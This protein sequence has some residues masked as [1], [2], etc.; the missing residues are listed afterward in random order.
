VTKL[1]K[2]PSENSDWNSIGTFKYVL[3]A[4]GIKEYKI[5]SDNSEKYQV[6]YVPKNSTAVSKV[7]PNGETQYLTN[8][9]VTKLRNVATGLQDIYM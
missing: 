9:L 8:V 1:G 7:S 2:P 5:Y 4:D 3:S 6:K